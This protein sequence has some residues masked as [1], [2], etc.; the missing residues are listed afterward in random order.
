MKLEMIVD[1]KW[2]RPVPKD[3]QP[4]YYETCYFKLSHYFSKDVF[5]DAITYKA[6]DDDLFLAT[7]PKSGTHWIKSAIYQI[8]HNA[9]PVESLYNM[10]HTC[11]FLEKHGREAA[12]KLLPPKSIMTHLPADVIPWNDKAKYLV[13]VRNPK[14]VVVSFYHHT[15]GLDLN[16][17]FLDGLFDDF[18]DLFIGGQ[19]EFGDYFAHVNSWLAKRDRKNVMMITFEY[20]KSNP[21]EAITKIANFMDHK[22]GLRIKSDPNYLKKIVEQS[23]FSFMKQKYSGKPPGISSDPNF[24]FIR[25]GIVNDWKNIFT[26]EQ[27]ERLTARF[28]EEASKNPALYDLWQDLSWLNDEPNTQ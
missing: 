5:E 17:K 26:K 9:E 19:G 12:E 20:I 13:V 15:R 24:S 6:K 11:V 2:I 21:E 8:Q 10:S 25:K 3:R 14:D 28:K 27:N 23:S 7:Y 22:Y 16:Y 1:A 4:L 18:F